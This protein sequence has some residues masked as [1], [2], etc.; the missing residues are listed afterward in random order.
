MRVIDE[1]TG[2]EFILDSTPEYKADMEV[3]WQ[4]LCQH[5]K[6]EIRRRPARGGAVH[7]YRQC[8]T[9]GESVG[10]AV[11]R[12]NVPSEVKP[13]D[14]VLG[15]RYRAKKDAERKA[16]TQKHVRIQREGEAGFWKSYNEYLNS[17]EWRG[18]RAKVMERAGNLCEGCR[19]KPATQVH[20]LHYRHV[21]AEFLFELVAVCEECHTRLHAEDEPEQKPVG[22]DGRP[23]SVLNACV[24]CRHQASDNG[25]AMCFLFGSAEHALAKNGQCGPDHLGFEPLH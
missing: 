16:I 22:E 6:A 20:H 1:D 7:F 8:L 25:K 15:P 19:S 10:S 24:G 9:C 18:K 11:G 14:D 5:E 17:D 3:H 12:A 23:N 13:W 2:K 21:F 4:S